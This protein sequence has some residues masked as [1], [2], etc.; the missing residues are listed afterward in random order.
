MIPTFIVIGAMKCGTTSLHLYLDR[1]PEIGMSAKKELNFFTSRR[2]F[3]R[4]VEW[5]GAQFDDRFPARGESS[6]SYTKCHIFRGVPERM[7]SVLPDCKLIYLVRNPVDRIV[8]QYTHRVFGGAES[9]SLEE[10]LGDL[11]DNRYI[12]TSRYMFQL[13]QFFEY[14]PEER[15][16]VLCSADLQRQRG[17]TL[18]RAFA[19]LGVDSAF[20]DEGFEQA[21]HQGS[22]KVRE[23]RVTGLLK[24]VPGVRSALARLIP[25]GVR[26]KLAYRGVK[27]PT[28]R[29]EMR[30]RVLDYLE[31]DIRALEGFVGRE[32]PEWRGGG[33]VSGGPGRQF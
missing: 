16:L 31:D 30:A 6:T 2:S 13:E 25:Q 28:M 4:G 23:R 11:S 19:F 8:S 32:F 7:H 12:N 14:Y 22:Q 18:A 24:R 26:Q 33:A 20:T 5:Y 10:A 27:R 17:E 1:H 21:H 3:A 29:P 9:R 15:F